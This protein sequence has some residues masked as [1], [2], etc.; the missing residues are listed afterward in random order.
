MPNARRH[1]LIKIVMPTRSEPERGSGSYTPKQLKKMERLG[2]EILPPLKEHDTDLQRMRQYCCASICMSTL[3]IMLALYTSHSIHPE[4]VLEAGDHSHA[5][6]QRTTTEAY[7]FL[8][9]LEILVALYALYRREGRAFY[10]TTCPATLQI[11]V[12][13][14]ALYKAQVF[15]SIL[16]A[17]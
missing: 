11:M 8:S 6:L 3:K 13:L 15:T 17:L 9:I 5:T 7:I 14:H 10:A 2:I 1:K 4:T 16:R 12:L